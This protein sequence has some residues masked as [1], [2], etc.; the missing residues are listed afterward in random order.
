M[1]LAERGLFTTLS[2]AL[3]VPT[4]K[5]IGDIPHVLSDSTSYESRGAVTVDG[6]RLTPRNGASIIVAPSFYKVFSSDAAFTVGGI[7]L[8]DQPN[9]TLDT[10]PSAAG[11]IPL[12]SFPR[13]SGGLAALGGFS[14]AGNVDVT[15]TPGTPETPAGA[16]ISAHLQLPSFLEVGG[17]HVQGDV[18]L[19]GDR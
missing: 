15:L 16:E 14:L 10:T 2:G 1:P 8:H 11:R 6:V 4:H 9:F 13:L 12:G 3:N 19:Q 18:A 7:R 17:V 5:L